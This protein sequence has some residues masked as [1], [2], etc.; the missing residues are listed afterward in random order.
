[1]E[2]EPKHNTTTIKMKHKYK[3]MLYGIYCD[4]VEIHQQPGE[5]ILVIG[6]WGIALS[7]M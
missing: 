2:R 6:A 7:W 1:M 4:S 5:L 3:P